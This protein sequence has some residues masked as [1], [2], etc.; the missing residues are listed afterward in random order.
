[1][2]KTVMIVED[3]DLNLR[4]YLDLMSVAGYDTVST[5]DAAQALSLARATRPDVILLDIELR[6]QSGLDAARRLKADAGLRDIPIIAV[7][8]RARAGD[9]SRCR[10]EGCA[11]Y[12]TKPV[13]VERLIT[14]GRRHAC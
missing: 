7:T 9:E 14:A 5:D 4:L 11:D 6:S 2:A 8:G 13:S 3:D 1:M 12:M 10:G